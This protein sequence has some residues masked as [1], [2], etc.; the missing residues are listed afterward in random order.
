MLETELAYINKSPFTMVE[1]N[2]E[3]LSYSYRFYERFVW[4]IQLLWHTGPNMCRY[5][6]T[7]YSLGLGLNPKDGW[8]DAVKLVN[9]LYGFDD[10]RPMG[11]LVELVGPIYNDHFDP[12]TPE[13]ASFLD[14]HKRVVYVGFGQ[15][16]QSKDHHESTRVLQMLLNNYE[17]GVLDGFVWSATKGT[18]LADHVTTSSG[19]QYQLNSTK[20][21]SI[22]KI[23]SWAPQ[24]AV[25]RHPSV[26]TFI[27]H[28]G[29]MSLFES[30]YQGKR[31]LAYPFMTDQFANA[32]LIERTGAGLWLTHTQDRLDVDRMTEKLRRVVEDKDGTMQKAVNRYQALVQ[33][34]GRNS[35]DRAANIVEEVVFTADHEGHLPHR[36]DIARHLS[37]LKRNNY[38]LY[39]GLFA[40]VISTVIF[41]HYIVKGFIQR[42]IKMKKQ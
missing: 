35:V 26:I 11:P 13:L 10:P 17:A 22:G 34:H 31:I 2:T 7:L 39:L 18:P 5:I 42:D 32:K 24:L 38:D 41:I 33:I 19:I 4:P 21:T 30:M 28:A 8:Q 40:L 14:T 9:N 27:S 15:H 3:H 25:L 37:F 29:I 23:V 36:H 12:L 1:S 20:F 6:Y 16:T